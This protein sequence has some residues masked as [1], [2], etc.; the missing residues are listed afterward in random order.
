[1][2][3][4]FIWINAKK[5]AVLY[6]INQNPMELY[7]LKKSII[8][9][10]FFLLKIQAGFPSPADDYLEVVLSLD[11]ICILHLPVLF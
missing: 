2:L 3:N 11:D 4:T 6:G 9:L 5:L 8:E 7:Q 10:P 1:M